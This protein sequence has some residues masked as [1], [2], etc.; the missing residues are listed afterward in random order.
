MA[1]THRMPV[2]L[3]RD[4]LAPKEHGSWSLAFEPIILALLVAPSWPGALLGVALAA[5]FFSR[6]PLRIVGLERRAERRAMA[7][8]AAAGC[9]AITVTAGIAAAL[10]GG[11]AWLAWLVPT[12]VAGAFF[13]WFDT[14]GDGR[15]EAAEVAGAAAFALVPAA[16]AALAGWAAPASLALALV[17]LGRSVPSVLCVRAFLRAAKTGVARNA[18]ALLAALSA[19]AIA[20]MLVL[21]GVA[22]LFA[23]VAAVFFAAR[24]FILLVTPKPALRAR[25]VGMLEAAFGVAFV[26]GLALTWGVS[27]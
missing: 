5:G 24:S 19:V 10:L 11:I 16:F 17:M 2:T 4:T 15:E 20:A 21:R 7:L 12:V 22:P 25:T 27:S 18:T 14:R 23:L 3:W 6:R 9:L 13:V 26:A 8:R 1:P